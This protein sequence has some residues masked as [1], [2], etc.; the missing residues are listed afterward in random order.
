MNQIPQYWGFCMAGNEEAFCRMLELAKPEKLKAT[1]FMADPFF[2][3]EIGIGHGDTLLAVNEYLADVPRFMVGVDVPAWLPKKEM[4]GTI[5]LMTIGSE[6]FLSAKDTPKADFIFIDGCHGAPC[7]K[8]DFLLA[9]Q[10]IKPGGIIA[11]HDTDPNCQGRHFQ[12]HCG[13]GIDV[14]QAL[15]D[16]GLMD[17]TRPGWRKV[18]ETMGD[19]YRA[20][21]G[22]V[23]VQY[24]P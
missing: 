15:Q 14:R 19:V 12:D 9:E 10:K 6:K 24:N 17:D 21:H 13:T 16:L 2:Y 7:V 22:M 1:P 18:E 20:G 11:F 3:Y 5:N 23:F 8:R 4:P